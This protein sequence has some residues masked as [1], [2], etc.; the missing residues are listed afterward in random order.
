MKNNLKSLMLQDERFI[1]ISAKYT[2]HMFFHHKSTC[3]I[4]CFV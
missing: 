2:N 4:T 1:Q 3:I